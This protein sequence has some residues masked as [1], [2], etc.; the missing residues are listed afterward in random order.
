MKFQVIKTV[1]DKYNSF[2]K[3]TRDS[4]F[5]A[6]NI[7]GIIAI[8]LTILGI[9]F[10][11]ICIFNAW[12]SFII[13]IIIYFFLC[14]II[15]IIIGKIFKNSL[16]LQIWKTHISIECGS[17]FSS[18]GLKVIGCDSQFSTVVDDVIISKRSLHGQLILEH[19]DK[20]E[21]DITVA[22]ACP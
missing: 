14:L 18:P 12:I 22:I 2:S 5:I 7:I 10:V 4:F 16:N 17:I 8:I 3:Q 21:I 15:Y 9:S 13:V 19:G 11:T 20:S 6:G 1:Y